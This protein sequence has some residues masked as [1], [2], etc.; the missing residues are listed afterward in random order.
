MTLPITWVSPRAQ[1]LL[2]QVDTV[3][4]DIDG[5]LL[6][7]SHS[8]RAVN[9]A[10]LP[11]YLQ[12]LPGWSCPADVLTS[13]EIEAF[14]TAGGFNDDLDL[15]CALALL[16]LFKGARYHTKNA[17]ELHRLWPSVSDYTAGIAERG[18]WLT[19][20]EALVAHHASPTEA[21][22]IA[23]AYNA[24]LIKQI[25]LELRFGNA[26]ETIYDFAPQFFPGDGNVHLDIPLLDPNALPENKT[27]AI[28]TGRTLREAKIGLQS[29]GIAGRIALPEGGITSDEG[30]HKPRPDGLLHLLTRKLPASRV[31]L[32]VGDAADDMR[33]VLNF[34][35]LPDAPQITVLSAQVLTGTAGQQAP[36][37]AARLFAQ[38]DLCAQDV[39]AVLRLLAPG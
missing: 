21:A 36:E 20:A 9:I 26:C 37:E 13:P 3:I 18:G 33:T 7:V 39:N 35:A 30:Y 19:A 11:A 34:R 14:K 29:A 12:M 32:Y 17:D 4:F 2:P 23:A 8:I 38:A 16:F 5:V 15:A 10:A 28:M 1:S 31:A 25:F 6:D 22:L 27:L 24:P